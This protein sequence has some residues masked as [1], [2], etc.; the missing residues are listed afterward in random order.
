[1]VDAICEA[2]ADGPRADAQEFV[3]ANFSFSGTVASY[4]ELAG[5]EVNGSCA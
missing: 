1:M 5:V 4:L 3:R 2:L